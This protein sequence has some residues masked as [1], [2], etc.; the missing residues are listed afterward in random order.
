MVRPDIPS[1]NCWVIQFNLRFDTNFTLVWQ[2]CAIIDGNYPADLGLISSLY[3][4]NYFA[5]R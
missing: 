3:F 4:L 2:D 1:P 5:P